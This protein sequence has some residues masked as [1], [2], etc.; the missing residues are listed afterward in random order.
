MCVC[1]LA[2]RRLLFWPRLAR[3]S[4]VY[5]STTPHTSHTH[6][7]TH[8]TQ[9]AFLYAH[10]GRCHTL[11]MRW[12]GR[13]GPAD[14][15][16]QIAVQI[17]NSI[18]RACA[19][20]ATCNVRARSCATCMSMLC[21]CVCVYLC[22][23]RVLRIASAA[24]SCTKQRL[25]ALEHDTITNKSVCSHADDDDDDAYRKSARTLAFCWCYG[26]NINGKL[27]CD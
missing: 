17:Y 1:L 21:V 19:Y 18:S 14:Q 3:S 26:C 8:T 7:Q 23:N 12:R 9:G 13:S 4:P 24:S 25:C 22:D 16:P 27:C 2:R 15:R 5:G 6:T 20:T 11:A 10:L